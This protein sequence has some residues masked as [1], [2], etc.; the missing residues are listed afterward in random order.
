MWM[1]LHGFTGSPRSW[2]SVVARAELGHE[3][4]IPALIGHGPEWRSVQT[5]SFDEEISR[6]G[7]MASSLDPPRYLC[8]YSMGAR[9]ALGLLASH[10]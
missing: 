5:T 1:L 9:L 3:P 7:S 10:R 6:L 8:G 4:L 2:D